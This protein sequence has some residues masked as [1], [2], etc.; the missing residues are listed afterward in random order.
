MGR[1]VR[2]PIDGNA[3][4]GNLDKPDVQVTYA[5]F[6]VILHE[7]QASSL[8]QIKIFSQMPQHPQSTFK[9]SP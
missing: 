2:T 5:Q 6:L 8:S 3:E 7:I 4:D 9:I 1:T